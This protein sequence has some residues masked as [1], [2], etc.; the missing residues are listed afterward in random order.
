M[1]LQQIQQAFEPL[2]LQLV[3][4][5][6][7]EQQ[8]LLAQ[9]ADELGWKLRFQSNPQKLR[10]LARQALAEDGEGVELDIFLKEAER[11]F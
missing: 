4:L 5:S 6:E 10:D 7:T 11:N 8:E 2:A 9:W 1:N 3:H